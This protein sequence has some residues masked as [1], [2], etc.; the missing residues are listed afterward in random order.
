M[1]ELLGGILH[2]A[3]AIR[4]L[5]V[6]LGAISIAGA[7]GTF[8]FGLKAARLDRERYR[9]A[10][11]DIEA[12]ARK[13]SKRGSRQFD[14]EAV[15]C[16]A[17][18]SAIVANLMVEVSARRLPVFV[19]NLA[20]AEGHRAE[21]DLAGHRRIHTAKWTLF[22]PESLF[23]EPRGRLALV[24]DVVISGD[25]MTHL[26]EAL[27]EGGFDSDQITTCALIC[28]AVAKNSGKAPDHC[29]FVLENSTFYLPWGK[30]Y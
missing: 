6:A 9:F 7:I 30:G 27:V 17:G 24:D 15:V 2:A 29:A 14:A 26:R 1:R 3:T 21:R 5:D 11:A 10:W 20:A 25:A 23:Q 13:L 22:V 16:F 19:V 4:W 18:P 8:A 12:G 28:T